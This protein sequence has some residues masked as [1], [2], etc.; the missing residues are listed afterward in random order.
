MIKN[1]N[2]KKVETGYG[3]H[4]RNQNFDHFVKIAEKY[5]FKL[6]DQ[7]VND[8]IFYIRLKK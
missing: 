4:N 5:G 6:I 2:G 1:L 7:K 8:K 3:I